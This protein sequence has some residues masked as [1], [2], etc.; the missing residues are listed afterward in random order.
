MTQ[1]TLSRCSLGRDSL[2]GGALRGNFKDMC[3]PHLPPIHLE[4]LVNDDVLTLVLSCL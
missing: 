2:G 4:I 3:F 1:P